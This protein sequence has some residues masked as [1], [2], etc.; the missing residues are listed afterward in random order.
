MC[1]EEDELLQSPDMFVGWIYYFFDSAAKLA[2]VV[3]TLQL[4]LA[5]NI[6]K[7]GREIQRFLAQ[8]FHG[9]EICHFLHLCKA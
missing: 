7:T 1:T 3:F 8:L 2:L 4:T 6:I 5:S 9:Q